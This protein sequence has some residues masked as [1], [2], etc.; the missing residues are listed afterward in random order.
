[1]AYKYL[2]DPREAFVV[3]ANLGGD[4]CHR[5]SLLGALLGAVLGAHGLPK[6][7]VEGLHQQEGLRE[8]AAAFGRFAELRWGDERPLARE[9]PPARR[10]PRPGASPSD[11]VDEGSAQARRG[12]AC[13]A[14]TG[15]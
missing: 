6:D 9:V 13:C 1:M 3:N 11:A 12:G 2:D 7:M 4:S 10:Q 8:V 14:A 15:E 5:G